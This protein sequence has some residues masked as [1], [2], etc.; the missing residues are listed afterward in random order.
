MTHQE[1]HLSDDHQT[2][3]VQHECCN[4]AEATGAAAKG[5]SLAGVFMAVGLTGAALALL[6]CAAPFLVAGA[7]AAIG[8]SFLLNDAILLPLLA[9]FA[10]VAAVGYFV[11]KRE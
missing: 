2:D 7:L 5:S 6:C 11:G 3:T 8:L 9:L 4:P 1:S 10:A